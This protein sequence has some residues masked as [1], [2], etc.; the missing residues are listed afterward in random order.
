MF[1]S[2]E[3]QLLER[4]AKQYRQS[5]KRLSWATCL[6]KAKAHLR[7]FNAKR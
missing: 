4:V 2:K 7:T 3:D 5:D 6:A 1:K